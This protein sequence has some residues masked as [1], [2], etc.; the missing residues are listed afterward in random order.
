M[1]TISTTSSAQ[2]ANNPQHLIPAQRQQATK[3][4]PQPGNTTPEG[5]SLPAD[6]AVT[7]RSPSIPASSDCAAP[8]L[9]LDTTCSVVHKRLQRL[10]NAMEQSNL[11]ASEQTINQLMSAID[12]ARVAG[13]IVEVNQLWVECHQRVFGN[14]DNPT[15]RHLVDGFESCDTKEQALEVLRSAI[16]SIELEADQDIRDFF[17]V[18]L[19]AHFMTIGVYIALF[20]QAQVFGQEIVGQLEEALVR[21]DI[22]KV[23]KE[24]GTTVNTGNLKGY[25]L[26]PIVFGTL[27]KNPDIKKHKISIPA[28]V[29]PGKS[30]E[31]TCIAAPITSHVRSESHHPEYHLIKNQPMPD[32]D[33]YEFMVDGLAAGT[34]PDR[35]NAGINFSKS[36]TASL[37][38]WQDRLGFAEKK[39]SFTPWAALSNAER[40][41]QTTQQM[42]GQLREAIGDV[43]LTHYFGQ[44][45]T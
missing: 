41:A 35:F 10:A 20:N 28:E 3:Q 21:H 5:A 18:D 27:M 34:R 14:P 24:D 38:L 17:F 15:V 45:V 33:I 23:F 44:P 11:P 22:T 42:V 31:S 16:N 9:N 37:S 40:V 36:F 32:T 13:K 43:E 30:L 2:L 7:A 8:L 12:N 6:V 39:A 25:M 19:I 29:R 1:E 26:L 4:I